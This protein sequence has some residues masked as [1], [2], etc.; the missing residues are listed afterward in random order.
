[1]P[2]KLKPYAVNFSATDIADFSA[3]DIFDL[4]ASETDT[5]CKEA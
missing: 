3:T 4:S 1:M 2:M 5:A